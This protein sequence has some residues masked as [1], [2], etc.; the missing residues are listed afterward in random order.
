[1]NIEEL[2]AKVKALEEG[3]PKSKRWKPKDSHSVRLLPLPG[4]EDLALTVKWHYGVDNGRQMACPGTWGDQCDFCDLEAVLRAWKDENGRDKPEAKRKQ[5]W[6]WVKKIG[7]A[8]KHYAPMVERVTKGDKVEIQGPFLWEMTPKTYTKLMKI[9]SNADYNDDHP[10]GG[11]LRV[12]T[13][14]THGLDLTV[15]LKK[16][17]EKGNQTTFDL[18]D[19]EER[20]K[21]SQLT[22][23]GKKAADDIIVKIPRLEDVA[24][25]VTSAQASQVFQAWKG[26][27]SSKPATASDDSTEYGT[28]SHNG[29]EAATGGLSV[30][31]TVAKLEALLEQ[32]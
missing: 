26:S 1:M 28:D 21:F 14:T 2:R 15:D 12:L 25:P 3:K 7:A 27:L 9:C 19:V 4:E 31:E 23:D 10:D 32:G 6:E 20:R 5:D 29:E 16:A 22:K 11:V 30:D 13:S 24:K 17:G 8:T 18:T